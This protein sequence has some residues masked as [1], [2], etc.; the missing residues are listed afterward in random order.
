MIVEH[1]AIVVSDLERSIDFY[2]RLFG[3]RLLRKTSTNAFLY[4]DD[5]L[6]EL[7]HGNLHAEPGASATEEWQQQRVLSFGLNH[8]GFRVDELESALKDLEHGGAG[9]LVVPP[10]EFSPDL[11]FVEHVDDERLAPATRPRPGGKWKL[12]VVADPD[13]TLIELVQR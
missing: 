4:L 6:L 5:S 12:A 13:G 11:G 8:I 9:T 2:S 3:F 7:I 1:V 10:Y